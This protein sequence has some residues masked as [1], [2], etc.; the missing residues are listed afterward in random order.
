MPPSPAAI[1]FR[2]LHP[3]A[4]RSASP[5]ANGVGIG[6]KME[7][8]FT[9]ETYHDSRLEPIEI[10]ATGVHEEFDGR[11]AWRPGPSPT[12]GIAVLKRLSA[13]GSRVRRVVP[14]YADST[15]FPEGDLP[16]H[17]YPIR[18]SKYL[19]VNRCGRF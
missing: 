16:G 4:A 9:R 8:R 18:V 5:P 12:R 1:H 7:R 2:T 17:L 6:T 13:R 3:I 19:N 15:G 10:S 11:R 14:P